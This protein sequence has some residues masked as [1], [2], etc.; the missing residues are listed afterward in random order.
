MTDPNKAEADAKAERE[1]READAKSERERKSDDAKAKS[2][3]RGTDKDNPNVGSQTRAV[4]GSRE[5][6]PEPGIAPEDDDPARFQ[7]DRTKGEAPPKSPRPGEATDPEA[8]K[9]ERRARH[10]GAKE[11]ASD[12]RDAARGPGVT[13][14]RRP[15]G[16]A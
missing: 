12:K 3:P 10:G 8:D 5:V 16:T 13:S 9:A 14:S 15:T 4:V 11:T 2:E 1:R 7:P 6:P